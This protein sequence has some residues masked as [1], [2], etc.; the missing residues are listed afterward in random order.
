MGNLIFSFYTTLWLFQAMRDNYDELRRCVDSVHADSYLV[1]TPPNHAEWL[2]PPDAPEEPDADDPIRANGGWWCDG[3]RPLL[4]TID[5]MSHEHT[6]AHKVC[7][8]A[9]TLGLEPF[10]RLIEA[11]AYA[12]PP[13]IRGGVEG[14]VES[15]VEG[16]I[17]G[18][19]DDGEAWID[20]LWLDFG[21]GTGS[22]LSTFLSEW[23]PKV[24]P[25]GALKG[26]SHDSTVP[27]HSPPPTPHFFLFPISRFVEEMRS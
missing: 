2:L 25:G 26:R 1:G 18:G 8:A 17:E 5:S 9:R 4:H 27:R 3:A 19:G 22:R 6:T 11:D 20:V 13:G 7:A 10:L 14:G 24:V 12:L 23:W 16:G 15:G 21:I